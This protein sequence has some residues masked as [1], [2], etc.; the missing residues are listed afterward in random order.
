M[1]HRKGAAMLRYKGSGARKVEGVD[2]RFA[3]HNRHIPVWIQPKE[4]LLG[5]LKKE[6]FPR[7]ESPLY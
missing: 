1:D 6:K 2:K 3:V 4:M 5:K 7:R